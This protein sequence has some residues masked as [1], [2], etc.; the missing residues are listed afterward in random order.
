ML[1]VRG[2]DGFRLVLGEQGQTH[3]HQDRSQV[4]H[5]PVRVR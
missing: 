4:D 2:A 5:V 1:Q 3:S